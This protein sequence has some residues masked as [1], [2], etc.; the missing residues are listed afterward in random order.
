M[1]FK[2]KVTKPVIGPDGLETGEVEVTWEAIKRGKGGRKKAKA[3][4]PDEPYVEPT[5]EDYDSDILAD[6]FLS[7]G[8]RAT[9]IRSYCLHILEGNLTLME[10]RKRDKR[11]PGQAAWVVPF[12]NGGRWWGATDDYD[13]TFREAID[14]YWAE[15]QRAQHRYMLAETRK[16]TAIM[17]KSVID[18]ARTIREL[19]LTSPNHMVRLNAAKEIIK[20]QAVDFV[21]PDEKDW[22]EAE[23]E[24]EVHVGDPEIDE[25]IDQEIEDELA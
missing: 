2:R 20:R 18:A 24:P 12:S 9:V 17:Q 6:L 4:N 19:A 22:D 1:P 25:M 14:Q 3:L 16:S 23:V 5:L 13:P 15:L 7:F 21:T 10:W 11:V 8:D